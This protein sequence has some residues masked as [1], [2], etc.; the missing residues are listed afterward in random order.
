M[1]VYAFLQFLVFTFKSFGP[2]PEILLGALLL[3]T[4]V[5]Y[6]LT[7]RIEMEVLK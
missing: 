1:A 4:M 7:V 5:F 2:A 6:A 3:T